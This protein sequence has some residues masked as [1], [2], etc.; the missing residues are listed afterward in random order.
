[1]SNWFETRILE[2]R[3]WTD[4]LFSLRVEG[5]PLAFEAGQFVRIALDIGGEVQDLHMEPYPVQ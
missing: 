2:S 4:A 1:M 5:A 3:H